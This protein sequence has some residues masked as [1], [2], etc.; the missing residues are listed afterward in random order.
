MAEAAWEKPLVGA[1]PSSQMSFERLKFLIG[2][3]LILSAIGYLLISGTLAGARYYITVDQLL[4][5]T[6]YVGQSVRVSGAVIGSTIDNHTEIIN[7]VETQVIE[8]DIA[9]V[10]ENYTD[11]GEALHEAANNP[12]ATIVHVRMEG[13]PM[14]DLLQH[15]AQAITTGVLGSDGVFRTSEVLLKCPTRMSETHPELTPVSGT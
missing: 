3:V 14:P 5:S 15:E 9:N 2:G 6:E 7:G 4:S 8:F 10:P 13:K 12:E 1:K 11:L